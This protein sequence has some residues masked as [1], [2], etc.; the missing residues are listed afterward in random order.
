M[1]DS[2]REA[3]RLWKKSSTLETRVEIKV[4]KYEKELR[5]ALR[6]NHSK[7]YEQE[8]V[9]AKRVT[10]ARRYKRLATMRLAKKYGYTACSPGRFTVPRF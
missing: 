7:H 5:T 9:A 10:W 1:K 8:R 6:R 2:E 3:E 4:N